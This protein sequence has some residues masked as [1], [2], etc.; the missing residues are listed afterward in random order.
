VLYAGDQPGV[1]LFRVYYLRI[2]GRRSVVGGWQLYETMRRL[3]LLNMYSQLERLDDSGSLEFDA[4]VH[5]VPLAVAVAVG[6]WQVR[7]GA[8]VS[9]EAAHAG[10]RS[11]CGFC[12]AD[13]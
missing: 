8:T 5:G 13:S 10:R 1:Y 2:N 12:R 7:V 9:I 4:T 3:K 6:T 11:P